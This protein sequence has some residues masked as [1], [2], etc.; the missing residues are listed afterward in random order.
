[1]SKIPSPC[2]DV[3]KFKREGHCIGC[4]MTKAQKS[5]FKN[6][7]KPKHKEAYIEMLLAQQDRL[8][9]Y[10]HWAEGYKRKCAKK[11]VT[12]PLKLSA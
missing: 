2:L 8:G 3:C 9:R 7:K 12:P 4:S 11:G 1:M 10:S 6:L 5:L